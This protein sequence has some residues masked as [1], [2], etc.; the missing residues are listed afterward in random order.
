MGDVT[1]LS[2][3]EPVLKAATQKL[4]VRHITHYSIV[5]DYGMMRAYIDSC[6]FAEIICIQ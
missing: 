2:Q 6:L 1:G 4:E 3:L 5:N